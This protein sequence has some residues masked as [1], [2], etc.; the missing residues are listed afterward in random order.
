LQQRKK[1]PSVW[2]VAATSSDSE[3]VT[4]GTS[5]LIGFAASAVL[6]TNSVCPVLLVCRSLS[7]MIKHT[8]TRKISLLY[9]KQIT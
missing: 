8:K 9:D 7:F 5:K 1:V 6:S 2:L 4:F 3:A